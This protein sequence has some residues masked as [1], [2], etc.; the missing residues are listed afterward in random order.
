MNPHSA[1][2]HRQH[3]LAQKTLVD[4]L[5]AD[6][7]LCFTMLQTAVLA[8][9]PEH[10]R[11]A[12]QRVQ[13]GLQAIRNLSGRIEDAQILTVVHGRADDLERTLEK[14]PAKLP[15]QGQPQ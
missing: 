14:F 5:E 3:A 6:L 7:D 15:F 2:L 10:T 1:A 8:S 12:I 4:F 13:L 11:S 9:D